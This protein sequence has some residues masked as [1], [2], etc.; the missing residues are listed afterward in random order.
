MPD[1]LDSIIDA[2]ADD[3]EQDTS[4][5]QDAHKLP[6]MHPLTRAYRFTGLAMMCILAFGAIL[7]KF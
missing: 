1:D 2:L 5:A 3:Q 7:D 6:W 4:S